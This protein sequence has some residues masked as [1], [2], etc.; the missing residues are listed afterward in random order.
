MKVPFLIL[1]SA[2]ALAACNKPAD[3]S[4]ADNA[5][6]MNDMALADDSATANSDAVIGNGMTAPMA[7]QSFVNTAA[8]S[9]TFE[10]ASAKLAETKATTAALKT[11]AA[12][13][14]L[15]HTDSSVKLKAAAGSM[16]PDT[17][18]SAKQAS[19]L[20]TLKGASGADF[21][22]AYKTQQLAAH[23]DA[24]ALMQGYA[25]SGDNADLKG[26][27][28]KVAPVVKGHLAMLQQM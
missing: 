13:M 1:T 18:L 6:A 5:A 23:T 21:D 8:A 28:G 9:D 20:A 25:A 10:I 2:L 24:L 14:V 4:A 22:A 3:T 27:A 26:F 7:A 17:T 16:K 19:D 11:F 12:K 15:D